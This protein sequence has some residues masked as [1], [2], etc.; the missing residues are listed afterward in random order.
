V[1]SNAFGRLE[2]TYGKIISTAYASFHDDQGRPDPPSREAIEGWLR[3]YNLNFLLFLYQTP[4]GTIWGQWIIP[5]HLLSKYTTAADR[6]SPAPPEKEIKRYR[7]DYVISIKDKSFQF[8]QLHQTTSNHI[9]LPPLGI[10]I[11]IGKGKGKKPCGGQAA[12]GDLPQSSGMGQA[13]DSSPHE[14]KDGSPSGTRKMRGTSHTAAKGAVEPDARHMQFKE[15]LN[16]YWK[17]KNANEMPWDGSE[18]KALSLLLQANPALTSDTFRTCLRNRYKSAVNHAERIRVWLAVVTN[19][20]LGPLTQ[21]KTPQGNG[22]GHNQENRGAAVGR[23]QRS[24]DAFRE[25]AR[26]SIEGEDRP[27][28]GQDDGDLAGAGAASGDGRDAAEGDGRAGD[29][30]QPRAGGS[31]SPLVPDA[32]EILPPSQRS[33]RGD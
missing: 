26:R 5:P 15:I 33:P 20:S 22:H 32:P 12:A 8:Q 9:D 18:G 16:E 6:R 19:Y 24:I 21:Y 11:G 3:E 14:A 1:A 10:G 17:S 4:E 23:V 29:G 31:R 30:V 7:D 13:P 25:A 28:V 2:L 27:D